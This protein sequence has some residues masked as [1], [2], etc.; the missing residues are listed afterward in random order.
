MNSRRAYHADRANRDAL[1]G[2]YN[3]GAC[4]ADLACL[5]A[6][7]KPFAVFFMD[8]DRFKLINDNNS[9]QA[10]N[11]VLESF[12][13]SVAA[14]TP[15]TD[16]AYR[17]G[18]DEFVVVASR[19]MTEAERNEYARDLER[20]VKREV[21]FDGS[22]II[23]HTS[24][25][26]ARFPDDGATGREVCDVADRRMYQ[27]KE[28][29]HAEEGLGLAD[30]RDRVDSFN[31]YAATMRVPIPFF[32]HQMDERLSLLFVNE[33]GLRIC[34]ATSLDELLE[35]M[36]QGYS[37]LIH[38]DDLH[39]VCLAFEAQL[40]AVGRTGFFHDAYRL[41]DAGGNNH[42]V[43]SYAILVQSP[44]HGNVMYTFAVEV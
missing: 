8:V 4:E 26:F 33:E 5:T 19:S 21:R 6:K 25:G 9:H 28:R 22:V 1:T 37:E 39:Q 38:P 17:F 34:V 3:G 32:V 30:A 18:G 15:E 7:G 31:F 29:R 44:R 16:C 13:E 42:L 11:R 36:G 23:P 27:I 40:S 20:V 14:F 2:L 43:E 10:G 41:V 12:A 35:G 24:V